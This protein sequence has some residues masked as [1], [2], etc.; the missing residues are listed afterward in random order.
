MFGTV[1]MAIRT[2]EAA[3]V[4]LA[5]A[6]A[7]VA[8]SRT[9]FRLFLRALRPILIISAILFAFQWWQADIAHAVQVT[10]RML[11]LVVLA[12]VV[13]ATTATDAILDAV[14]RALGPLRHVG[15]NPDS[16]GLAIALMLRAIP[17]L[18]TI[19]IESREAAQARGLGRSPRALL[20]PLVVRAVAQA[21]MTGEALAARGFGDDEGD[22]AI[23][24]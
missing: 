3:V 6:V 4:M 1:A 5:L 13:T 8:W 15:I 12:T 19:A 20:V 7:C 23:Q 24:A 18:L 11:A 9:N 17:G 2:P 22:R 14:T 10:A 16:V 21:R